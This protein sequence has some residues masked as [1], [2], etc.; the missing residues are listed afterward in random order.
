MCLCVCA[1]VC[2]CNGSGDLHEGAQLI[3]LDHGEIICP[4]CRRVCNTVIPLIPADARTVI[5][6]QQQ[7]AMGEKVHLAAAAAGATTTTTGNV[8]E[9]L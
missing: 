6:Q 9:G 8:S 2:V 3:N 1:S 4:L 5:Q 7:S